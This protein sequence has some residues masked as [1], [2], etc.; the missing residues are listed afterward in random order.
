MTLSHEIRVGDCLDALRAMPDQSFHC[1]ITSPPY[2]GLR[3]YGMASQIG[4]EQTPAEFVARLVEVFREVRRVL[5]DDGTLWVNMGDSYASIAGGYAPEGSAGKHDIVSRNTRGAVRRGHRRKPAEGL[6]QKDLMGIPWRLAF[7][8]QDDGW[9]L[10]QDIIWHKPNP[11]P[12]S[13][14]DRCTKAHE[15]VFMLTKSRRYYYDHEA[16]KEDAVS[17]HPS[18]NGFKR[19][20][21]ESYKNLDGTARGNDEQW[22]GVGGKRNRRSVWTVPTAGF[23]GA[24]FATFPPDLIRPCV[25][26]G[27]PRGGLVLD[28]FGGAGTTALVAMQEGRRSVLIELNPEYAAIARNRLDTAWLEGAAQLDLLHD[29]KESVA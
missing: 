12:E 3:D 21:R 27:A 10:R 5:R 2:F 16:V 23:K 18:G 22:T 6:K 8:L 24:H 1:C 25:L 4:L 29:Q 19:D 11:M 15:Y 17:E 20:A 7:A 14:R 13:V 9:Y 28:P 26:A